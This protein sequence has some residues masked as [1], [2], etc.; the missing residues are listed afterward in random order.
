M[1]APTSLHRKLVKRI[2]KYL[3]DTY[4]YRLLL[5]KSSNFSLDG[6]IDAYWTFDLDD[7]KSTSGF[8]VFFEGNLIIWGSN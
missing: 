7:C 6:F 1:H 4:N 3:K 2:L 8:C 5:E